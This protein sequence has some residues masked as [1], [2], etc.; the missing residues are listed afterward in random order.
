MMLAGRGTPSRGITPL[1]FATSPSRADSIQR[2]AL[3]DAPPSLTGASANT[4]ELHTSRARAAYD[5]PPA[6][7]D[8]ITT[9]LDRCV[10]KV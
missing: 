8:A 2:N 5:E 7:R 1:A 6:G 3:R 9:A 10:T 4:N